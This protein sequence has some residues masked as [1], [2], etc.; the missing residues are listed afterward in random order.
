MKEWLLEISATDKDYDLEDMLN[1][2][3]VDIENMTM[4]WFTQVWWNEVKFDTYWDLFD[5]V[6]ITAQIKYNFA[7]RPAKSDKPF[8]YSLW[9]DKWELEFDDTKRFD[10]LKKETDAI[11]WKQIMSK[12]KTIWKNKIA[13]RDYLNERRKW[14]KAEKL[15]SYPLCQ[16]LWIDFYWG[17]Q[18][19]IDLEDFLNKL[20]NTNWN[21]PWYRDWDP[22]KITS[23]WELTFTDWSA[24]PTTRT[25]IKDLRKFK[26][27]WHNKENREKFLEFLND[28]NNWMYVYI[29]GD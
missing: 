17:E 3:N 15:I 16:A 28:R 27:I 7:W 5:K 8:H 22:Y 12:L 29:F 25:V 11:N 18:E 21:T 4:K 2:P 26:T 9:W 10:I 23:S 1:N 6:Y 13:Y 14:K 19:I 20:K 24:T